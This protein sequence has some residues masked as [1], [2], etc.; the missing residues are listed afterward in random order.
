MILWLVGMMGVGKTS[1]GRNVAGRL[2]L[3]FT[4]TDEEVERNAGL[5]IAAM[6]ERGGEELFRELES[7]VVFELASATD[8][9]VVATGGGAVLSEENRTAM[10]DAGKVVWLAAKESVL[11]E[12]IGASDRRPL[13]LSSNTVAARIAEFLAERESIYSGLADALVDVSE[14]DEDQAA[15]EVEALWTH[16]QLA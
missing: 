2:G 15:R 8:D 3:V 16:F 11:V 4:D 7:D 1:T 10:K 9:R 5:S 12:R 13:L 6:W 14:I